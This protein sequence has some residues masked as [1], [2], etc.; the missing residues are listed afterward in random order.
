MK[1][2]DLDNV[3][4]PN[5]YTTGGIETYDYIAAKL[6]PEQLEGY[7]AGNI[8]KYISR[9]QHKNGVEDLKKARWY[10]EKLI[11]LKEQQ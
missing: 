6:T 5:H 8:M 2:Y 3:N 10:L 7:L 4:H 1:L 9:Y 11:G